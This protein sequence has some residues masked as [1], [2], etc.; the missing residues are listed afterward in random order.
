MRMP[1]TSKEK[2]LPERAELIKHLLCEPGC[3]GRCVECPLDVVNDL[4]EEMCR[5]QSEVIRFADLARKRQ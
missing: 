4:L 1:R 3:G 5:L 2:T